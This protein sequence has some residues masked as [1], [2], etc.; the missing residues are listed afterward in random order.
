[1]RLWAL[2]LPKG[3]RASLGKLADGGAGSTPQAPVVT[4]N[5]RRPSADR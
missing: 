1:V 2:G 4:R 5:A 3:P